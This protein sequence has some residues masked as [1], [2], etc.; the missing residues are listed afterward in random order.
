MH[1]APLRLSIGL[2][3]QMP[4]QIVQNSTFVACLSRRRVFLLLCF[5]CFWKRRL[6]ACER[7]LRDEQSCRMPSVLRR[8]TQTKAEAK[9]KG[10]AVLALCNKAKPQNSKK[11]ETATRQRPSG[12]RW[13]RPSEMPRSF[14]MEE[15]AEEFNLR[16]PFF[17]SFETHRC[18]FV[19]GTRVF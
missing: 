10:S 16:I 13:Q 15:T 7:R 8:T 17:R 6:A 14:K 1:G 3:R 12:K 18:G 4:L 11:K 19:Q 9:K 2:V 5:L